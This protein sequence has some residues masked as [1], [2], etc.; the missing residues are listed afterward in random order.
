MR[1]KPGREERCHFPYDGAGGAAGAVG[2][3]DGGG[4]GDGEV[5]IVDGEIEG[6][7]FGV[8]EA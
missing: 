5:L 6:G 1:R 7:G 8:Y 4:L 2:G 3:E